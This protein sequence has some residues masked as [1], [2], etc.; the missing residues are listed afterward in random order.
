MGSS[1]KVDRVLVI[2]AAPLRYAGS[3]DAALHRPLAHCFGCPPGSFDSDGICD[4]HCDHSVARLSLC[5][6]RL[7]PQG[8]SE[9]AFTALP[10]VVSHE[11]SS[12]GAKL[13]VLWLSL[14]HI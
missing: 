6:T 8:A 5:N 13:K 9:R 14:I 12:D 1:L 11:S 4:Q 2:L 7:S 3:L 10:V